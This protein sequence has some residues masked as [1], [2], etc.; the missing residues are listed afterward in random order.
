MAI[1]SRSKGCRGE[2]EAAEAWSQ[3]F[4]V[5]ARRGQQF[6]GSPDSPDILT[7]HTGLH[8][9]VK[10]CEKGNPYDWMAQAVRDSGGRIPVVLHRRN[11]KEWILI[12]RLSDGPG[13]A[14]ELT[15]KAQA[16]GGGP[17]PGELS[18]AG[19]PEIRHPRRE[20]E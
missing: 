7:E 14:A 13:L 5:E 3:T 12:V 17:I 11:G 8:L 2:R 18:R 4:G 19:L 9:E 20:Q 10:R 1:D 15:K 16:L 6:S